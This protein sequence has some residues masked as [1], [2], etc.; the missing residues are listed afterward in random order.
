MRL[1]YYLFMENA[2]ILSGTPSAE[3]AA[4]LQALGPHW[5]SDI[6]RHRDQVVAHYAQLLGPMADDG[7]AIARDLAYGAM[8]RQV[9]DVHHDPRWQP[10][11]RDVVVFF[12]G[13]AFVRGKKSVNGRVYDNVA[14]WFAQ[15]G[16]VGVNAEYRLAPQAAYP[17][18]AQDVEQAFRWVQ[19]NIARYGGRPDRI[20]LM[21]HSAGGCHVASAVF[22]PACPRIDAAELAGAILVSAR[23][24]ADVLPDNPNAEGVRAYFGTD[25]A[26]YAERSPMHHVHTSDVPLLVAVAQYENPHLDRYGEAFHQRALM[27]PRTALA[28]FVSLPLHNHTSIVAHM[29]SG[30]DSLGREI[31]RF[32]AQV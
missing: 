9:L 20:F 26:L 7:I 16:M 13:G 27:P 11:S 4:L 15:Q 29:G 19:R 2:N 3:T 14:H 10:G 30:E 31:T 22:D 32:M 12:H 6:N 24:Q 23:L 21:G 8:E 25:A 18:G 28:R 17:A 5:A 1:V